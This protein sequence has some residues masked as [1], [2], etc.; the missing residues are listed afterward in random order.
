M[1]P[2]WGEFTTV[3]LNPDRSLYVEG[4]YNPGPV[5]KEDIYGEVVIPFLIIQQDGQDNPSVVVDGVATWKPA[6]PDSDGKY[7]NWSQTVAPED[8]PAGLRPGP[9]RAVGTAIQMFRYEENPQVP[10]GVATFT[11]CVRQSVV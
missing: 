2:P 9:V 5:K 8:V 1:A 11:W 10:P 4:P 3:R 6:D 7:P